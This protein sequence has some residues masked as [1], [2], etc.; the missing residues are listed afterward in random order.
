VNFRCYEIVIL[1]MIEWVIFLDKV[2][3][4]PDSLQIS[5]QA[6][7]RKQG[8]TEITVDGACASVDHSVA[9]GF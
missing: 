9:A 2:P 4:T 1:G 5:L 3:I 8:S 6:R 7:C